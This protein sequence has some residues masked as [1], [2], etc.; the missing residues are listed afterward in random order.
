MSLKKQLVIL[1]GFGLLL[2]VLLW[3]DLPG[4]SSVKPGAR[5]QVGSTPGEQPPV[6]VIVTPV[7]LTSNAAIVE[8]VGT[9]DAAKAVTLY[10]EASGQVTEILFE[11]GEIVDQGD[12]LLRLDSE[13]EELAL[14]LA[15][16][17]LQ[18]AQQQLARYESTAPSGAVS[19]SEVDRARTALSAARIELAQAE[20][21]L[22]KRTLK[23]P[24][25]GIVGIPDVQVGDRVTTT[26]AVSTLDDRSMLLVDF[27]VPEA[28]A[29]GVRVGGQIEA[30][31]WAL[32]GEEFR[33]VVDSLASRID[34]Q[35]RTLRVRGRIENQDDLLRTG[36][37]FTIRLP[38]QG[39]RLPSVPSIAVQWDRRGAYVWRVVDGKAERLEVDVMKREGQWILVQAPLSPG[40][41]I[42]VEGVQRLQP[43]RGVDATVQ[44][45]LAENEDDDD[46]T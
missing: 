18:D 27:E 31:S 7:G 28:F 32:R 10:P 9:G 25:A 8:A 1:A 33:G 13:D 43:G 2:A 45:T 22:R 21:A 26:T 44:D 37:S 46:G 15:G 38:L 23:A 4:F 16:V 19:T 41:R 36:M 42:V 20:L 34:P 14:A 3:W 30:T 24:F 12:P 5:E 29:Q 40:D 35:T 11:A 6:P 39:E 17:R